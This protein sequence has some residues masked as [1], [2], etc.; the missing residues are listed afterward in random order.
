MTEPT[1]YRYPN[2][3]EALKDIVVP[4]AVPEDERIWVPQAPM[5]GFVRSV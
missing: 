4:N 5:Y 3:K 1:P 2:P